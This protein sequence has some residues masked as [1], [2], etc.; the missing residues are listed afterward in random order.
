[1]KYIDFNDPKI[2]IGKR[3]QAYVKYAI[4][5]GTSRANACRQA[6]SKFGFELKPKTLFVLC[7][8]GDPNR[9][10]LHEVINTDKY[11]HCESIYKEDYTDKEFNDLVAKYKADGYIVTETQYLSR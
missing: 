8:Y 10:W 4:S 1:M 9:Y 5:K 11:E 7:M 2:P 6:N 3:K